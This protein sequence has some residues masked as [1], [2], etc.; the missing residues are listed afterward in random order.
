MRL[1]ILLSRLLLWSL[2]IAFSSR[3]GAGGFSLSASCAVINIVQD[4][5][6][7]GFERFWSAMQSMAKN[8]PPQRSWA[9]PLDRL[10]PRQIASVRDDLGAL[11]DGLVHDLT[12]RTLSANVQ[13]SGGQTLLFVSERLLV[14]SEDH[15]S[16]STEV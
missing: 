11:R 6:G 5:D 8:I 7:P 3:H 14:R 9:E 1:T 2:E 13:D 10:T 15:K 12:T 16:S 4:H